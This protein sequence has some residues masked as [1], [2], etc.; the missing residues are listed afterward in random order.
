MDYVN[1]D[2]YIDE[3]VNESVQ[4][5]SQDETVNKS[6]QEVSHDDCLF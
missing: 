4:E 6:A 5:V 2:A 1:T 3:T